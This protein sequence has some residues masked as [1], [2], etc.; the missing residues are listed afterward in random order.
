MAALQIFRE[1]FL[2]VQALSGTQMPLHVLGDSFNVQSVLSVQSYSGQQ[3]TIEYC[4]PVNINDTPDHLIWP[5]LKGPSGVSVSGQLFTAEKLPGTF[6][7]QFYCGQALSNFRHAPSEEAPNLRSAFSVFLSGM[8]G[9]YSQ[10]CG[11]VGSYVFDLHRWRVDCQLPG[12]RKPFW[13]F[14]ETREARDSDRGHLQCWRHL[15]PEA[16]VALLSVM[17]NYA[18]E[19]TLLKHYFQVEAGFQNLPLITNLEEVS[20]FEQ[21]YLVGVKSKSC[22][23][24]SIIAKINSDSIPFFYNRLNAASPAITISAFQQINPDQARQMLKS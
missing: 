14:P 11:E 6:T 12:D 23:L 3:V 18:L 16:Y 13:S 19:A 9:Y 20:N 22:D 21:M 7:I 24:R 17:D 10:E 15:I 1:D 2:N 8:G 5:I 4:T